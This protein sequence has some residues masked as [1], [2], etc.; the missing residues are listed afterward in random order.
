[1]ERLR[2]AYQPGKKMMTDGYTQSA[3][4]TS[5]KTLKCA[6]VLI[7]MVL[8]NSEWHLIFTRRTDTVDSHKG[9]VAFPGGG[10]DEHESLAEQTALREAQEEIGLSPRDVKILGKLNDVATITHYLVTPVVGIIPWPYDFKLSRHE[11]SR[12]FSIPLDWMAQSA[13]W[14][15][16]DYSLEGFQRSSPVITYHAYDG[17]I[18]W[19]VS[20]RITQ[21]FLE[22][23][24]LIN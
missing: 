13:N 11:V 1:M 12:V 5:G 3:I 24:G 4:L 20:A 10:C 14:E 2:E 8:K 18:L 7:P 22:V 9:Q 17:E 15:E 23:M 6:A 19:G 16:F 21:N